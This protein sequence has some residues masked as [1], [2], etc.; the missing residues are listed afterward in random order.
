M[1]PGPTC[2]LELR[3]PLCYCVFWSFLKN[4][5]FGFKIGR[6]K[7][8]S[9]YEKVKDRNRDF[10][11]GPEPTF[12]L[13]L[14]DHLCPGVFWLFLKNAGSGFKIGR[15]TMM[16]NADEEIARKKNSGYLAR[17]R[18]R[19]RTAPSPGGGR[20]RHLS[21]KRCTNVFG[22]GAR[23]FYDFQIFFARACISGFVR[24]Y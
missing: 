19:A 1:G 15:A 10:G 9:K 6:G 4:S 8:G 22:G 16:I 3:D 18:A 21:T 14:K 11:V 12:D 13:E 23:Q 2:D 7:I 17:A 24:F 20:L 5:T